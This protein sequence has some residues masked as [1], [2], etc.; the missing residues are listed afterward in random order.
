MVRELLS[1]GAYDSAGGRLMGERW[2]LREN[3]S[4]VS[5][6]CYA[7]RNRMWWECA[8]G[9]LRGHL[10]ATDVGVFAEGSRASER[11]GGISIPRNVAVSAPLSRDLTKLL[12][13]TCRAAWPCAGD[14]P[15]FEA[16]DCGVV[17]VG[18]SLAKRS[19]DN[20]HVYLGCRVTLTPRF[21]NS[22]S[23]GFMLLVRHAYGPVHRWP[24][25]HDLPQ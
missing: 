12:L 25:C 2:L 17:G 16:M 1:A 5:K 13:S 20:R 8:W 4:S 9:Y 18:E 6:R 15:D 22:K 11:L 23:L 19:S 10:L 24:A 3:R 21:R 14:A 7:R